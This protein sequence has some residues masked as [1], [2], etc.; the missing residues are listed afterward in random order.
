MPVAI[1]RP[2][3]NPVLREFWTKPARGRVL[4]GG[5]TSSKSWDAAGMVSF[6]A[7]N[8]RVRVLCVRQFQNK[9]AESVYTLLKIQIDRF[10]LRDEFEITD[11]SIFHKTTGSEFM[12]YGLA[13]NLNEIKSIE[14]VD[15]CWIEEAQFLTK[16]QWDILEPTFRKEGSQIWIIFNPLYATDFAYQRFVLNP[17]ANFVV[18]KINYDENPFLSQTILQVI[19]AKRAESEDDYRHIYLGVPREGTEGSVIKRSWIEASIDAHLKLGFGAAG[20]KVIGFDVAD[21]GED[22]CA[23]VFSHGSVALWCDEW[24]AKEDELL[25]SCSRTFQN[26]AL[27]GAEIRYDSI[28]VGA[29]A[30]AK[31]DELNQSRGQFEKIRYS[32]FNA[33]SAVERPEDFYASDRMD[34]IKNKDF[35]SN[36]KA[37]SW[38][39]IADRFRNTYNAINRG[40]KYPDDELI[41]ISSDMPKM[42]KLKTELSTPRR[43]FDKNGRVKVESKQDLAKTTRDG[44]PVPSPNLADAFVMA[45]APS[46]TLTLRVP[47]SAIN[48][49]MSRA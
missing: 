29:S 21:D 48:K 45:F 35:F 2:T 34:R 46:S 32:K 49:A 15:I 47:Q 14:S 13:R 5:R 41:S 17:P 16:E 26:A 4:Y 1:D 12:F 27:R 38:W 23:N 6:L 3:L 30:G 8:Y 31:F 11:R 40:E 43:D 18:R 28:G 20:R 39:N 44:G 7:S 42:E 19:E 37:Q 33:G 10:G 36:L 24:H 9:I 22:S 25:K